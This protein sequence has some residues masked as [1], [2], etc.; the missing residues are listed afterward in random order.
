MARRLSAVSALLALSLSSCAFGTGDGIA[1]IPGHWCDE[2]T[3]KAAASADWSKA[4]TV[5]L[6]IRKKDYD[7]ISLPVPDEDRTYTTERYHRAFHVNTDMFEPKIVRLQQGQAYILRV[8]NTDKVSHSIAGKDFFMTLGIAKV[9]NAGQESKRRCIAAVT[10][11][12][13]ASADI[14]FIA[15]KKGIYEIEDNA[16]AF[17]PGLGDAAFVMVE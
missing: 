4:K 9:S 1:W 5:S 13:G 8:T 15:G 17:L 14:H 11:A 6:K 10:I 12:S 7:T 16:V 2:G 3:A